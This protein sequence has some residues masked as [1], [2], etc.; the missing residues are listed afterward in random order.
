MSSIDDKL[1]PESE[2]VEESNQSKTIEESNSLPV[3]SNIL[4]SI[5]EI[6]EFGNITEKDVV[7]A[8]ETTEL[9]DTS[10]FIVF[11]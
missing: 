11:N 10:E 1:K 6:D 8:Q 2:T 4:I 7:E 5:G 9:P 3:V